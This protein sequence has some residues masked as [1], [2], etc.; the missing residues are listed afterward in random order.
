MNT[1]V[2]H[3][4]VFAT[5]LTHLEAEEMKNIFIYLVQKYNS[6]QVDE[7]INRQNNEV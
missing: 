1:K 3:I 6:K 7:L 4:L 2:T 5:Q